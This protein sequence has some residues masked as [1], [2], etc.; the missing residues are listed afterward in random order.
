MEQY[1]VIVAGG[2]MVG[3]AAAIGLAQQG[4]DVAVIEGYAPSPFVTE[5]AMDLRVSA[6]SPHSVAL[7]EQLGAWQAVMAMRLCPFKRLETWEHPECRTRFSADEMQLQQLGYIVENRVIQLAL[8]QQFEQYDNITLLC[9]ATMVAATAINEG[10]Q[11]EL[12][13]GSLINCGLLIGADGANSQVRHQANIG[14]TAWD[15]RQHCMLINI[16]T[17]LPQQDITWQQFTPAGPR[18]FLPLPGHQGSLVWYDTPARIRQLSAMPTMQLQAEITA[19]F[20][21]E[22][23]EFKVLNHGSFPLTRRHAQTYHKPNVVLLGDAAHTIN[24]LAGQGVNLGFKD[25]G[26]L[27]EKISQAGN[28]WQQPQVLANYERCRCPDN[29]IM[30]TGMDFFYSTF[31]NNIGPLKLLRNVGL[32]VADHTGGIKKQVLKYAM[33]I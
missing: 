21:T 31:S 9:P 33:G 6:I 14:I 12:N 5:Q 19:A 7:L 8:W 3:A 22:L 26:C 25:V 11:V 4:L 20:P 29:L 2:G 27:L 10:Y 28:D 30:Q 16:A 17:V 23:G 1:D 32:R 18:S 15:Y 24:P 13:D